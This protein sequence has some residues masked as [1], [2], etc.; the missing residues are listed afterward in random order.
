LLTVVTGNSRRID[1]VLQDNDVL[2]RNACPTGRAV[3]AR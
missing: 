1:S 2:T 3:A